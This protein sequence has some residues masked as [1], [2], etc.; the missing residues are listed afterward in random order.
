M[1]RDKTLFVES[2]ESSFRDSSLALP[3]SLLPSYLV[4]FCVIF[5]FESV[6]YSPKVMIQNYRA[7][8][9]GEAGPIF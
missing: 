3:S 1:S 7:C 5:E 6:L 8:K 2:S 9:E 4:F